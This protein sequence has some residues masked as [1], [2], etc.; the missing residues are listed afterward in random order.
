M[1]PWVSWKR[2]RENYWSSSALPV[3]VHTLTR[4]LSDRTA[5]LIIRSGCSSVQIMPQSEGKKPQEGVRTSPVMWV[6]HRFILL[7]QRLIL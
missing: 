7:S 5:R 6:R 3:T 2:P 4:I 1:L